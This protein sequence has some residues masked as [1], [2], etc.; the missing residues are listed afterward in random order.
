LARWG[1]RSTRPETWGRLSLS[2]YRRRAAFTCSAV[3]GTSSLF[4]SSAGFVL[5]HEVDAEA[6]AEG[7][8]DAFEH[9]EAVAVV[10]GV[11]QA[12]DDRLGCPD[13]ARQV[14]LAQTGR[15][16]KLVDLLGNSQVL[17]LACQRRQSLLTA[18]DVPPV[19]WGLLGPAL[20]LSF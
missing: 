13:P 10:V 11:L 1:L 20:K 12:A 8:G 5:G 16:A 14:L 7:V 19:K 4:R 3:L 17:P 2:G 15:G 9:R 6:L 18:F